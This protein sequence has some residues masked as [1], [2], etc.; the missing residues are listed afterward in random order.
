MGAAG[1]P[2]LL[3]GHFRL[4]EKTLEWAALQDRTSGK[5]PSLPVRFLFPDGDAAD[6]SDPDVPCESNRYF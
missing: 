2:G 1:I 5:A 6:N 3:Q 4:Y